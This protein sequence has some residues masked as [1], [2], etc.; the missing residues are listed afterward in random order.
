MELDGIGIILSVYDS[1]VT[2]HAMRARDLISKIFEIYGM[3]TEP[4]RPGLIAARLIQQMG[5]LQKCRVFKIRGV[6]KLIEAYSPIQSFTRGAAIQTIRDVDHVNQKVGFAAHE[7]LYLK[8]RRKERLTPED[9]FTWLI[10]HEVFR[11]GLKLKCPSCDLDFWLSLDDLGTEVACE[12]C[13]RKFNVTPQ[14]RDRDWAYRRSGLFGRDDHQEG[15]IPIVLTL[16]QLD[17]ILRPS[18]KPV[19]TTAQSISS[20]TG[21]VKP[22]ETDFILLT[23][24]HS[25]RVQLVIGECKS[26]ADIPEADLQK[27]LDNLM[28]VAGAF[29]ASHISVY[30]LFSKTADFTDS[31]LAQFRDAYKQYHY[32]LILLSRRELE[33]YEV[34]DWTEKELGERIRASELEGMASATTK[35]YLEPGTTEKM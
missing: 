6:R 23:R 32:P 7:S 18:M 15:G 3:E 5:D 21:T 27:D 31:E 9:A 13:G 35:I 24:N 30:V 28:K 12:Y 1:N 33:P 10:E 17:T 14:L 16:Q 8:P 11:A 19:Y 34:Y 4:S 2:L 22:C 29:S 25:G 20:K 26:N